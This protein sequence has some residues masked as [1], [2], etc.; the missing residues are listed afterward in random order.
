MEEDEEVVNKDDVTVNDLIINN[1]SEVNKEIEVHL[2]KQNSNL[3]KKKKKQLQPKRT[4]LDIITNGH[5]ESEISLVSTE[6]SSKFNEE[7]EEGN[8][9]EDDW[10]HSVKVQRK[11]LVRLKIVR[12]IKKIM[13]GSS[14]SDEVITTTRTSN[15]RINTNFVNS[16]TNLSQFQSSS[17]SP[18]TSVESFSTIAT[19]P[20][21]VEPN[22]Q[23]SATTTQFQNLLLTPIISSTSSISSTTPTPS[24]T[25]TI[26]KTGRKSKFRRS[27]LP[28]IKKKFGKLLSNFTTKSEI[29]LDDEEEGSE[30]PYVYESLY[31]N[32]RGLFLF[33]ARFSSSALTQLDP[34]TFS[35]ELGHN[36][37]FTPTSFPLPPFHKW[38]QSNW[39]IDLGGDVD[40]NGMY[41]YF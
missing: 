3:F 29:L 8:E 27:R 12:K 14:E 32:Q 35:D 13:V 16:N 10:F 18:S 2:N 17:N 26:N 33:G 4:L 19:S 5:K 36:S 6:S 7:E 28:T 24:R 15:L 30:I 22:S 11:D 41:Y 39:L 9:V 20:L 38:D 34:T 23:L 21:S 1:S 37:P 40:E 25:L 31:E